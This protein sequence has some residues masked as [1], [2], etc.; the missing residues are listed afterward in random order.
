MKTLQHI[1]TLMNYIDKAKQIHNGKYDYSHIKNIVKRDTRVLI[2]CPI[3]GVFEQ[4]MH[5]HLNGDGCRQCGN[6]EAGKNRIQKAREKFIEQS[7]QV[8][9]NKY[10]YVNTNYVKAIQPITV[11]CLVHGDFITTPYKHLSGTE[12]KQCSYV[13]LCE[14]LKIPWDTY[15]QRFLSVHGNTYDYSKVEWKGT[16]TAIIVICKK[17]GE[18]HILPR[19]HRAGQGCQK[20]SKES[21]IQYNKLDKDT[22]IKRS[23]EIWGTRYNYSNVDYVDSNHKVW[24]I[25]PIHGEFQQFPAN[26]YRYG[27]GSCGRHANIRTRELNER[28]RKEF[29]DKANQVH[30][31]KYIYPHTEYINASTKLTVT[32]TKHG[33]FKISPN[34]HLRGKGCPECGKEAARVSKIKPC[35]EYLIQCSKL[36]GDKYD[37]SKIEWNGT[38]FPISII[39]K[40]HGSLQS[41]HTAIYKEENVQNVQIHIQKLA[42]NG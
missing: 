2:G 8:H 38:S 12:C 1:Y 24:I 27:C 36:Y 20:C 3:H 41:Y 16:E 30:Q 25:C 37:Y 15:K 6:I 13:E 18:F 5:K 35:D 33:N 7:N 40:Q 28:C 31:N 32:C 19:S 21:N 4:S 17:H 39:C 10:S 11:T 22:F 26:H 42:L 34:N 14:R 9:S 29:L 23:V